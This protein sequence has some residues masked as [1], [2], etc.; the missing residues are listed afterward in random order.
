MCSQAPTARV[1]LTMSSYLIGFAVGQMV[2]GPLS[3][4][5]GR[6]PVLLAALALYLAGTLG[7]RRVAVG[8]SVDRRAIPPGHR[9]VGL[10]RTVAR[11]RA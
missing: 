2:Y 6:R 9:R 5:H 10:D 4:R 7:L 8:R 11:H 3:D 1:Q